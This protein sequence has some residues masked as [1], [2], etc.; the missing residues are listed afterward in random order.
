MTTRA[1]LG[2]FY[3]IFVITANMN[4]L[5]RR[6][7]VDPV[8]NKGDVCQDDTFAPPMSILQKRSL[9]KGGWTATMHNGGTLYV[10]REANHWSTK[11]H[12]LQINLKACQMWDDE[13]DIFSFLQEMTWNN[14]HPTQVQWNDKQTFFV[15][16]LGSR[17]LQQR[18]LR[19]VNS[20]MA[21][22]PLYVRICV[23][24]R[25]EVKS[26]WGEGHFGQYKYYL[27]IGDNGFLGFWD[28]QLWLLSIKRDCLAQQGADVLDLFSSFIMCF[29][30]NVVA[31][32]NANVYL[33]CAYW[34]I[35][36]HGYAWLFEYDLI[37]GLNHE[38]LLTQNSVGH[39]LQASLP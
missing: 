12:S 38:R 31:G 17:T 24:K 4:Y 28:G 6:I 19:C 10:E 34:W 2:H 23:M 3:H 35:S 25:K 39:Q 18:W 13:R 7:L 21:H 30:Q 14:S 36:V 22:S 11:S 20:L 33:F 26:Q 29:D 37:S 15:P 1:V 16:P 8:A 32:I 5:C 9:Q 27:Q